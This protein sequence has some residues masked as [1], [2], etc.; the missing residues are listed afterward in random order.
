MV[1]KRKRKNRAKIKLVNVTETRDVQAVK[2]YLHDLTQSQ[3][4][5]PRC[6]N[7]LNKVAIAHACGIDRNAI[8]NIKEIQ[9]LLEKQSKQDVKLHDTKIG[10][11]LDILE[12]YLRSLTDS[13]KGLL[14]ASN[15]K[16]NKRRIAQEAGIYRNVLYNYE[17]ANNLLEK[18]LGSWV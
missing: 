2:Q 7:K 1:K 11:N 16:P 8:Y 6:G 9:K 18:Y 13:D 5:L 17:G 3:Q 12:E 10:S 15:G 4:P 14:L